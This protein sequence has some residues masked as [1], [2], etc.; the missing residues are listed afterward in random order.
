[1][2]YKLLYQNFIEQARKRTKVPGNYIERHH[3]LP[4]SCGGTD[5]S[6]NIVKLTP[7]EHAFVHLLLVKI[8]PNHYGLLNAVL[9]MSAGNSNQGRTSKQISWI[10]EKFI[11]SQRNKIISEETRNKI[12]KTI[13]EF[14]KNNQVVCPHCGKSGASKQMKQFHFENCGKGRED[15][16]KQSIRLA[17][18][19]NTH[20]LDTMK[21]VEC[22]HCKKKGGS[23]IMHRHHFNNCPVY[24]GKKSVSFN[25]VTCP[26]CNK[27]G[28]GHVMKRWHFE[29]CKFKGD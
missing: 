7:R 29:N 19:G 16:V 3:I 26:H 17:Q 11:E 13:K 24:T 23:N 12:S 25:I 21:E 6:S 9:I 27:S 4:K 2:N 22:P 15:S 14:N 5:D 10:R 28:K 8:Y 1:M 20:V 18:L